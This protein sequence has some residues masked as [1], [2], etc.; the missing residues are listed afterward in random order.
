MS[1]PN[2]PEKYNHP[3]I[4]EPA[5]V[6][7]ER[8]KLGMNPTMAIPTGAI[9]CY[10]TVLWNWVCTLPNRIECDGW[11]TGAF[12]VQQQ[13]K[14]VLVMKAAGIGAPTAVM[15]L[16]E[17]IAI[18]VK[19][20]ISLG[21]AG[22]IQQDLNPGDIIICE[23][24]IRDEG[25]SHH[26]VAAEKFA[27]ASA[28]LTNRLIESVKKKGVSIRKG[29]SWTTDAPYRETI[30]ELTRYRKEGV[31]T[32]EMEAAALFT[33][34]AY[35]HVNVSSVFAISDVLNEDGW[36]QS[37]YSEEKIDG[38]QQIFNAALETLVLVE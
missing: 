2:T 31:L 33:V 13:N 21:A 1:I 11:L 35:R 22:G 3:A 4:I 34:A 25:T 8:G 12:I 18:G 10:D 30:E 19:N 36:H 5:K 23:R 6:I 9:I 7:E 37:Y 29:S 28:D 38:L 14:H 32:V 27:H 15:T 24:A 17:L 20:V 16:E 26:Y